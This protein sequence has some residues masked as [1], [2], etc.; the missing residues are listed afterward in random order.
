MNAVKFLTTREVAEILKL[1]IITIY[2]Y[3]KSGKLAS[4]KFG[5]NY[6]ILESDLENFVKE[7]RFLKQN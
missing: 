4:I 7:H 3:V 2:G 1:N 5:R 6:R